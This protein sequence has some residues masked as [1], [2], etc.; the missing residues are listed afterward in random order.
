[1][2]SLILFLLFCQA[3]GAVIGIITAIW[4]E[5]AYIHA[6]HDGKLDV[7]ERAHLSVIAR[8]LRF[9]MTLLLLSSLGLV[10]ISF[11]LQG[12]LQPAMT[13]SYWIF[14][15]LALLVIVTSWALSRRKV[16]FALGSAAVLTAWWL[17]AYLTLGQ[18]PTLSFTS[19][20]ALYVILTAV[21]YAVLRYIRVLALDGAMKHHL[22]QKTE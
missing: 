8:G 10:I 12:A 21:I 18:L 9:G 6:M 7:A 20:I 13:A 4:G 14:I 3:F 11:A 17:L 15:A 22:A 1:M 19:A 16:S 5:F 2:T